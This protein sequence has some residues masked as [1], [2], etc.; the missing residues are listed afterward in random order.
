MLVEP[1]RIAGFERTV[2]S[3]GREIARP[4]VDCGCVVRPAPKPVHAAHR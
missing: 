4:I 1:G 2:E 3:L